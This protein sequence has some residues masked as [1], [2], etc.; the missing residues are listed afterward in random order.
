MVSKF[1][2]IERTFALLEVL[3]QSNTPLGLRDVSSRTGFNKSTAYRILTTL[4]K[5]GYLERNADTGKYAIGPSILRLSEGY[6]RQVDLFT[7]ARPVLQE[8]VNRFNETAGL[9]VRSNLHRI[10]VLQIESS[11]D[12]RR[13]VTIGVPIPLHVGSASKV[14]LAFLHEEERD[15]IIS[16]LTFGRLTAKT[17]PDREALLEHLEEVCQN[18]CAISQEERIE[19]G[20]GVSAPV[21]DHNKRPVAALT[22]TVPSIRFNFQRV[23]ILAGAVKESAAELSRYLAYPGNVPLGVSWPLR[24]KES[25]A[26][27]P[28]VAG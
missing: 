10:L 11:Q 23:T 22:V 19:G 12:L 5:T 25:L 4:A 6:F 16:R 26:G 3:A 7:K 17:P 1:N 15:E 13:V 21:F 20:A 24:E 28:Q 9:S 18:G 2:V 14:L 27:D 8:L